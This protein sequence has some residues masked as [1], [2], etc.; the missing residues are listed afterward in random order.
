MPNTKDGFQMLHAAYEVE[1]FLR[2]LVTRKCNFHIAFFEQNRELCIPPTASESSRAK[3]LLA[4]ATIIRHLLVN[5]PE[6]CPN[7]EIHLFKSF[8]GEDFKEYM[9]SADL[10]FVLCH[11]GA[12]PFVTKQKA[13]R[14]ANKVPGSVEEDRNDAAHVYSRTMFRSMIFWFIK[15]GYNAALVNGLEWRDTKVITAIVEGFKHKMPESL[16]MPLIDSSGLSA[17][18]KDIPADKEAFTTIAKKYGS[19]FDERDYLAVLVVSKM[20]S[21]DENLSDVAAAFLLHIALLAQSPLS[22]RRIEKIAPS[23]ASITFLTKFCQIAE[24]LLESDIW[25]YQAEPLGNDCNVADL[26][27]G[28]VFSACLQAGGIKDVPRLAKLL[29]AVEAICGI[30][31]T[32]KIS[33]AKEDGNAVATNGKPVEGTKPWA[34]LPFANPVFDVYL[35][36]ITLLTD[37]SPGASYN[38]TSSK[39]FR[40]MSHWHNSKRP[41]DPKLTPEEELR[42]KKKAFFAARRNQWFMAEMTAYAASLTNAVGKILDP[43]IITTGPKSKAPATVVPDKGKPKPTGNQ[44]AKNAKK[45]KV[46]GG[47]QAIMD[48]I[49]AARSKREEGTSEKLVQAWKTTCKAFETEATPVLRYKKGKHHL[50]TLN[51]DIKRTVLSA[52]IQLY[53][54]NTLLDMW[55]TMCKEN[56]KREGLPIA[57]M[58]FNAVTGLSRTPAGMTKTI[59]NYLKLVIKSLALPQVDLPPADGDRRLAFDLFLTDAITLDLTIPLSTQDFQLLHY[60]PYFDRSIDSAPDPRVPFEPDGWQRKVLDEIDARR[61]LLVVAPTSA[62]KTFISFYAMKQVLE[63]N[64]DDVL[65]YVAPTKALVNQ[66]AAEVQARFSKSFKYAGKSVWGIHTRDYR[67]NNPTGCQILVTVPH[68]LQIMLLSPTH[69]NG[70]SKRV[71]RIIFDEVHCIGQAEDG[72]VWEQLLLLAPCPIIALSATIGNPKEFN[73]WLLSTQKAL[74]NDLTMVSHPHRYSDLRKFIYSPPKTF[75]FQSLTEK[76]VFGHLGLDETPGFTFMHPVASLVNK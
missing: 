41:I 39:I 48:D 52:E 65:V 58:I 70:W 35:S 8:H 44:N 63:S 34:V 14:S 46:K 9:D 50:S 72:I 29:D 3:Y 22:E 10:Y 56:R 51:T 55:I 66:I 12:S 45:G 25:K 28:R 59:V 36:A 57:A 53:L 76:P 24:P 31:L 75:D 21:T 11:D 33:G 30:K 1:S 27:D 42:N 73:E 16:S 26:V 38:S 74:G 64:D 23:A 37:R 7:I 61:S 20:L 17:H 68:I 43:E 18:T 40:E 71:K 47:K 54:L 60:G 19:D 69:A 5:L 15:Q 4:R 67:I 6:T 2:G 32:V 49:A 13:L 62:G